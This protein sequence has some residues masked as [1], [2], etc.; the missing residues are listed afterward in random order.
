MTILGRE[1]H[2]LKPPEGRREYKRSS[3]YSKV[4]HCQLIQWQYRDS[5]GRV[6]S[7][8]EKSDRKAKE[9]AE[10][11]SGEKIGKAPEGPA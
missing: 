5:D 10:K 7:G 8:I 3:F 11:E 9:A 1:M 2:Q 4:R 6:Y